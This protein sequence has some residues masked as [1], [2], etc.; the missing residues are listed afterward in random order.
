MMTRQVIDWRVQDNGPTCTNRMWGRAVDAMCNPNDWCVKKAL[1]ALTS[2]TRNQSG[3]DL[4]ETLTNI[5]EMAPTRFAKFC[6]SG[7]GKC[8]LNQ[9]QSNLVFSENS[10]EGIHVRFCDQFAYVRVIGQGECI[11]FEPE[12][13]HDFAFENARLEHTRICS[14]LLKMDIIVQ[15]NSPRACELEEQEWEKEEGQEWHK[16]TDNERVA[17]IQQKGKDEKEEAANDYHTS[18][19]SMQAME[20]DEDDDEYE[21]ETINT[22]VCIPFDSDDE[23][24]GFYRYAPEKGDDDMRFYNDKMSFYKYANDGDCHHEKCPVGRCKRKENAVQMQ[25]DKTFTMGCEWPDMCSFL[26]ALNKQQQ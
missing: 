18:T 2:L 6:K 22:P 26:A 20:D 8:L 23:D 11:T 13:K 1:R 14:G 12:D 17:D 24:M 4:Q 9:W 19:S 7:E 3:S 21:E 15:E 10:K 5:T 16:V 25:K